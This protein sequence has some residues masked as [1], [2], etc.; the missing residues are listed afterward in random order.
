[1]RSYS[2]LPGL[3]FQLHGPS[4]SS[5]V[6][7]PLSLVS[8]GGRGSHTV[9]VQPR[10]HHC[11]RADL[12]PLPC[13]QCPDPTGASHSASSAQGLLQ[14]VLGL[15]FTVRRFAHRDLGVVMRLPCEFLSSWGFQSCVVHVSGTVSS[16]TFLSF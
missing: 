16:Y 11:L 13:T 7:Q 1:M 4:P 10:P 3:G 14:A 6:S 9:F 8:L 5:T 15:Q 2:S 12:P